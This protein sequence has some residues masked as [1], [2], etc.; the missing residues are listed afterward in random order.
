ME[1]LR[2]DPWAQGTGHVPSEA[3]PRRIFEGVPPSLLKGGLLGQPGLQ[4]LP[5]TGGY[6]L[7]PAAGKSRL[8]RLRPPQLELALWAGRLRW[9][10]RLLLLL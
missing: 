10:M 6:A 9:L 2:C 5:A 1:Q 7:L 4:L 3:L 8:Q